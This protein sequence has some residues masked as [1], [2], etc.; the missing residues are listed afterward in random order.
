MAVALATAQVNVHPD[1]HVPI[2]ML[3]GVSPKELR[4]LKKGKITHGRWAADGETLVVS[5]FQARG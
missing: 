4:Y 3:E 2:E 5:Y 1:A